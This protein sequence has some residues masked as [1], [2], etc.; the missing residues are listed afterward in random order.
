MSK[1]S[2]INA[3]RATAERLDR[4]GAP[5]PALDVTPRGPVPASRIFLRTVVALVGT[6]ASLFVLVVLVALVSMARDGGPTTGRPSPA[7]VTVP[8]S[9]TAAVPAA[10]APKATTT[11][12]APVLACWVEDTGEM[13]GGDVALMPAGSTIVP[14][15]V[16]PSTIVPSTTDDE[17]DVIT[18]TVTPALFADTLTV[19]AAKWHHA[20][21]APRAHGSTSLHAPHAPHAPRAPRA[22]RTARVTF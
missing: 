13:I 6:A 21:R 12:T 22:P 5:V 7:A 2:T 16:D 11:A 15:T 3:V 8:T 10:P 20:P 19:A 14:C 18:D 9:P 4:P 1:H 17:P